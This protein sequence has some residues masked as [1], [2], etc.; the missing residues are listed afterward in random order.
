M[1]PAKVFAVLEK[2]RDEMVRTLADLCRIPAIGP[3]S[4]GEGETKK[5]EMVESLLNGFGTKVER[6]DARDDR[7]PSGIRPNLVVK[8]GK[9]SPRLW[10]LT[11][12]DV[13]PP[14]DRAGWRCDPFDPRVFNGRLYGRGVEDNGQALVATS[15]A[16]K[17]VLDVAGEPSRPVGLCYV[18]DEET[19]SEKGVRH[20]I[21]KG[22]FAKKDLILAPDRGVSDG[23]EIEIKE[24]NLLWFR[25]TVRGTQGHASRPEVAINAHRAG[26]YL[27]TLIDA[28]L[29]K[30]FR[31]ADPLFRPAESTFEPTKREANVPNVNTI[32]GEDVFYFDCRVLPVYKNKA[33]FQ[34][35]EAALQETENRFGVKAEI[36]VI[37]DE[38]SPPTPEA[39]PIVGLLKTAIGTARG[40]KARVVGIGGGTVA[41]H[42]RKA[43]YPAAVWQTTDQTG[44][45]VDE[46]V[47][48]ANLVADAKVFAALMLA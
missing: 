37:Q 8:T 46:Y 17:A 44:H 30:K 20:V 31:A 4:N 10:L 14:G 43:G 48:I 5:A 19:G 40:L 27:V 16:L 39:A 35:V 34:E 6:H 29:H 25:V 2:S 32:P 12:L 23:S 9:G 3:A 1:N 24:K 21:A 36:E 18:S 15:Y 11:H 45:A 33:V 41:A 7:V 47:S 38:S 42:F 26:A 28:R 22:L 13:V